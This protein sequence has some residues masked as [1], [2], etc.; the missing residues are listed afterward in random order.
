VVAVTAKK[1]L[2]ELWL[3]QVESSR[4]QILAENT[5]DTTKY[6]NHVT[7]FSPSDDE[8]WLGG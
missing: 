5:E 8:R 6:K 7:M 3:R 2:Q 4:L 1:K